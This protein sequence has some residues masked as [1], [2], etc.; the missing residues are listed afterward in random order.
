MGGKAYYQ[1]NKERWKIYWANQTEE[2]KQACRDRNTEREQA[3]KFLVLS[4]YSNGSL[5]CTHCGIADIDVLSLDHI[6]GG[7]TQQRMQ[8]GSHTYRWVINNAFP[9]GFQVLCFNC[10]WKKRITTKK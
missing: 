8:Y 9:D 10:N 6:N 5:V 3:Q 2:Q 4:H 7:G 1:Q